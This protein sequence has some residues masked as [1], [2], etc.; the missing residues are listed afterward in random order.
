MKDED[1]EERDERMRQERELLLESD[2]LS[3]TD[4]RI[5]TMDI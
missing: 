3:E 5:I 2:N 4:K 1:D